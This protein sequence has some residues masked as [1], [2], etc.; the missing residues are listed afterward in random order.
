MK[1][2]LEPEYVGNLRAP[3]TRYLAQERVTYC[4]S[5]SCFSWKI[6]QKLLFRLNS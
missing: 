3:I 1:F 4:E 6:G 5:K 2:K